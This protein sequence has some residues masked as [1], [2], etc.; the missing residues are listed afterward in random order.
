MNLFSAASGGPASDRKSR[1]SPIPLGFQLMA[2]LGGGIAIGWTCALGCASK[3]A[4]NMPLMNQAVAVMQRNYVDQSALQRTTLT[5]GAISGMVSSLGDNGHTTFL[6]PEMVKELGDAERG[7]FKG[8]G[9]EIRMK[10]NRVVVVAPID[11]SPAQRAGLRAGDVIMKVNDQD[12]TGWP[13]SRVVEQITGP[14]GSKV[15]LT[16][17]NT[18]SGRTREI[19]ITRASI[20]V[21]DVTWA[22]LPGTELAH[23]RISSFNRNVAK[24]LHAALEQIQ[25][26]G[27]RGIVLDLRN[28]PGG[29]LDQAV[30]VASE[31]LKGGN[32]LLVKDPDGHIS[33]EPVRKGGI[34]TEIPL[35]VLINQG[36]ASAAEIVAGALRDSRDAALIGETTFGTGT[37]LGEFRLTDGSALLLAIQEWLTP[38]GES[39]WHKG[40]TPQIP[41]SLP[42]DAAPL[43]PENERNMTQEQLQSSSDHQ[44]LRAIEVVD[45]KLASTPAAGPH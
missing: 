42:E 41:V 30:A 34:A 40:I 31:F 7:E 32:V 25:T 35:D 1:R 14:A 18:Q 44:L 29:F 10:N 11:Q 8:I 6:S 24:D 12:I 19:T 21:H 4:L 9:I 28:N 26:A 2:M 5:Y 16:I 45:S 13:L 33:P 43:L 17:L 3:E 39:F 20:K 27:M 15:R 22:Q 37:V 36:S 38:K 23:L